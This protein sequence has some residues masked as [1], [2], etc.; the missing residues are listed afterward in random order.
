MIKKWILITMLTFASVAHASNECDNQ[1]TCTFNCAKTSKDN[2]TATLDKTSKTLTISG[3]GQMADYN[4]ILDD[5]NNFIAT[6]APWYDYKDSIKTLKVDKGITTVGARAFKNIQKI[7]NVDLADGLLK[8]GDGAFNTILA[9]K[10][11]TIPDSVTTIG[12]GT[13]ADC[14]NL[15]DV[16][17]S[18]NL[19]TIEYMAFANTGITDLLLPESVTSISEGIVRGSI[20]YW[21]KA[22]ILNL[23]CNE[24]ISS[25][26]EAALQWR[27]DK[28]ANVQVIPYQ[29]ASNGQVFYNNKWY[30]SAN[31]ILSGEYA[32]KRIYTVDEAN[33]ITGKKNSVAIKYK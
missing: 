9:L 13:F 6:D 20:D 27:K 30:N 4:N 26:C 15:K 23:Y 25:Q 1:N 7:A 32:K 11:I 21:Q 29:K 5:N 22:Q 28:G 19:A 3:S 10:T 16:T 31:D 17:L 2:C 14:R 8:I 18:E 33:K 12:T 24:A